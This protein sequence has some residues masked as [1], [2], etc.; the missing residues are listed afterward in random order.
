MLNFLGCEALYLVYSCVLKLRINH[1]FNNFWILLVNAADSPRRV[2][3]IYRG[4]TVTCPRKRL[5]SHSQTW[6]PKILHKTK[7]LLNG[8]YKNKVL[9]I[10]RHEDNDG[11]QMYSFT[12][13][14]TS[15]ETGVG[16]HRHHPAALLAG[17]YQNPFEE[18]EWALGPLEMGFA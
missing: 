8:Y 18:A 3:P 16:E 1:C 11:K 7:G 13:C 9:S 4:Y 5:P 2:V 15:A 14:L 10:T 12:L 17:R 6:K